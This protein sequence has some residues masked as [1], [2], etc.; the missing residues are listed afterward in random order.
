MRNFKG[1]GSNRFPLSRWE[2]A[3]LVAVGL[4]VVVAC[5]SASLPQWVSNGVAWLLVGSATVG[6]VGYFIFLPAIALLAV[7]LMASAVA[8]FFFVRLL[9]GVLNFLGAAWRGDIRP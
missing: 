9:V 1:V 2:W 4:L 8:L 3:L 7:A 5:F 6:L